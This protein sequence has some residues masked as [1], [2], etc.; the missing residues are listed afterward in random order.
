M[1]WDQNGLAL[2]VFSQGQWTEA[3]AADVERLDKL[4]LNKTADLTNR[5]AVSS[6]A[7]LLTHD[8]TGG[9]QLKINKD[10]PGDT[11][12]LLFQTG[13]SYALTSV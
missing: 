13:W 4:G 8:T 7:T 1:A 2:L 3:T 12:S 9:H 11:G 5:L 10:Q 6:D